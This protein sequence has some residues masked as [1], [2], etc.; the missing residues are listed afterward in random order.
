MKQGSPQY[1]SIADV[2]QETGLSEAFWRRAIFDRRIA[3][4]KFGRRVMIRRSDLDAWVAARIVQEWSKPE[5][6]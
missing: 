1:L 4:A 5:D 2:A 6:R 3:Y